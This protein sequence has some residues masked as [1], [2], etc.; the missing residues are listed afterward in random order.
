MASKIYAVKSGRE[1]GLFYSWADCE[2][3]VKGYSGAV[4]KSFTSEIAAKAYLNG[5]E[6]PEKE[7]TEETFVIT[8]P[9]GFDHNRVIEVYTDGACS[10]NPGPGGWG[11]VLIYGEHYKELSGGVPHTT[12]NQMELM[13]AI[14]G[15]KALSKP[16]SVLLTSDSKYLI[17]AMTQGW[18]LNWKFK[19]NWKTSK[20]EDVKNI[21]LWE[22]IYD[23][24]QTHKIAWQW[25]KGHASNNY[26]NRCDELAT[27]AITTLQKGI[28]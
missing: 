5:E 18:L 16:S 12:N 13:A 10:G 19:T 6:L 21:D 8:Y 14:Q 22:A 20:K 2:K 27:S 23:L 15:L 3:Q 24:S 26:N 28:F 25:V 17:D 7:A 9:E 1:T 4:Y 11:V